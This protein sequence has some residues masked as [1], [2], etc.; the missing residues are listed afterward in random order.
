MGFTRKGP[1]GQQNPCAGRRKPFINEMSERVTINKSN[2]ASRTVLM[3]IDAL[4]LTLVVTSKPQFQ[5]T[6]ST[7]AT[8][9]PIITY[10]T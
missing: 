9:F 5:N 8:L 3:N 4:Y 10:H 2:A 6:F 7:I 1:G